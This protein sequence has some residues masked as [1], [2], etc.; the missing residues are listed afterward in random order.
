[1]KQRRMARLAE[2][3]REQVAELIAS[4]LKDPRIGFVTVTRVELTSDQ[5]LARI[6][7]GVLGDEAARKKT[8]EGLRQAQGFVRRELAQRLRLRFTPEVVFEFDRDLDATD[9]VARLLAEAQSPSLPPEDD[10]D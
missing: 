5:R 4:K 7:F 6:L 3:I 2:A 10:E 8:L 1:M 9:R